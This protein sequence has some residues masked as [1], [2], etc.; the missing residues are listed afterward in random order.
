MR[1]GPLRG[2]SLPHFRCCPGR[3]AVA[4]CRAEPS[5]R[6]RAPLHPTLRCVR[7]AP[8]VFGG[9]GSLVARSYGRTYITDLG[10]LLLR[11]ADSILAV[12]SE[13]C[14]AMR[15]FSCANTGVVSLGASQTTGTYFMPRLIAA[16]RHR[17][18]GITVR[19]VV[20]GCHPDTPAGAPGRRPCRVDRGR[21]LP[22]HRHVW[23]W[24]WG[25]SSRQTA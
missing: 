8:Q 7:P 5:R 22:A 18:P 1:R 25:R 13:A 3:S 17:Y 16:F 20:R 10:T 12:A 23:G 15:D 19:L 4:C 6:P 2:C 24:G 21:A 9:E 11:Y 14:R